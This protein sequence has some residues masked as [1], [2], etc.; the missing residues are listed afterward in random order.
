MWEVAMQHN[1]HNSTQSW[2]VVRVYGNG[3]HLRLEND[4]G[5]VKRF[6]SRAAAQCAADKL[7]EP[8]SA[9]AV[10]DG[11]EANGTT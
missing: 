4:A 7:N 3:T 11:A 5:R 10:Q 1:R 6:R 9:A 8:S 2:T